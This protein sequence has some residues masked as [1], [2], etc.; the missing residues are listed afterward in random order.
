M[1]KIVIIDVDLGINIDD[2]ITEAVAS[3]N[4]EFKTQLDQAIEIAQS[5]KKTKD[6]REQAVNKLTTTMDIA[7]EALEK[8]GETGLPINIVMNYVADTITNPSAFA[9][10]MKNILFQKGNKYILKRIKRDKE[11]YYAFIKFNNDNE[12]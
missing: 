1:T 12:N 4:T 11:Q 3:Y 7:Y 2:I 6:N 9:L 8:A 10:R 5:I